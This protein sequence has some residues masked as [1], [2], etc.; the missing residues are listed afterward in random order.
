M[1]QR[2]VQ[3]QKS[4]LLLRGTTYYFRFAIPTHIRRLCPSLPVEVKRSLK[5]D[6]LSEALSLISQK[7]TLIK[8]LQRCADSALVRRLVER[9]EDFSQEQAAWVAEQANGLQRLSASRS[10]TVGRDPVDQPVRPQTPMLSESWDRFV[11]WKD[12]S[13]KRT[14]DN[15]RNFDNVLFF[16]GDRPVGDITKKMLRRAFVS[17]A[18]LPQRNLR[19]YRGKSLVESSQ[20][21]VPERYRIESRRP[22][23]PG[24]D[25]LASTTLQR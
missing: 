10:A 20:Q 24:D 16:V 9:L 7:I 8:L 14:A 22:A 17:I 2:L 5:T 18:K 3:N 19:P 1:V 11:K 25:R 12:W 23:F 13:D 15:Q 4:Y 6:S 21:R